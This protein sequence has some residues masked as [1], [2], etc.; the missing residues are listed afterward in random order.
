M[1]DYISK[2][3][4]FRLSLTRIRGVDFYL[5]NSVVI[6]W[7]F[8]FPSLYCTR[9]LKCHKCTWMWNKMKDRKEFI[10]KVITVAKCL[11]CLA[12]DL[13]LLP[14]SLCLLNHYCPF[15]NHVPSPQI[16]SANFIIYQISIKKRYC[17]ACKFHEILSAPNDVSNFLHPLSSLHRF[18]SPFYNNTQHVRIVRD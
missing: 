2:L 14:I 13:V 15:R 10:D 6:L 1:R 17:H 9:A 18:A 11:L 8:S 7:P 4:I 3:F 5:P 16:R 12:R